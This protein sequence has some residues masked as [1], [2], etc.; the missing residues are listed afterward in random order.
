MSLKTRIAALEARFRRMHGPSFQLMIV[1]GCLPGPPPRWAYVDDLRWQREP[2]EDLEAFAERAVAL[3][4]EAG[5]RALTIGGLPSADIEQYE[6]LGSF[7][8]WWNEIGS[9]GYSDVPEPEAVGYSPRRAQ[10]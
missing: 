3:A 4:R 7:D 1:T 10:W 6:G 9:V 2:E 5:K 8:R